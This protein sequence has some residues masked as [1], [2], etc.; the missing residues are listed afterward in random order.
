M[1]TEAAE[2]DRSI[3]GNRKPGDASRWLAA[4]VDSSDDAILS[5]D[6]NGIITSWN[7]G[8]ARIFGYTADEVIG[9]PVTILMPPERFNEEPGILER[10]RR[11]ERVEH[12]ETVRRRKDGVL[13][14]ISLTVSPIKDADGRVIGASKIARDISEKKRAEA[15]LRQANRKIAEVNEELKRSRENLADE[16]RSRTI[17]LRQTN[18]QLEELVYTIAHDLRAPLRAMQGF[19][20]LLMTEYGVKLDETAVDYCRRIVRAAGSM[21]TLVRDLL[22]YGRVSR[23]ELPRKSVNLQS[24]WENAVR[25]NAQAIHEKQ[26]HI[27]VVSPLLNVVAH[28]STLVQVFANLL[29]NALKFV[30][31]GV[32]PKIRFCA[33]SSGAGTV[34]IIVEDNGIGIEP[35]HRERVFRVFERLDGDRF[36]GTGIGLSI[37]R[38]GVERMGGAVGVESEVGRGSSFWI[39]LKEAV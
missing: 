27:E 29:N 3:P 16:V 9:Q 8:A 30:E 21:D 18:A 1:K 31:P 24:A 28:E 12:Y 10:I 34:K 4:I 32:T 6:L 22:A 13:L 37:V 39:E 15:A 19:A 7:S 35:R 5:K 14:D 26:A 17:E 2:L 25:Q 20:S 33:Q 11:G 36:P 38:K 23:V